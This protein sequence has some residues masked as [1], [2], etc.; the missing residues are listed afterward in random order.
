MSRNAAEVNRVVNEEHHVYKDPNKWHRQ[1]TTWALSFFG[2]AIGAGVLFL[3]INIGQGG[4]LTLLLAL[5]LAY[6]IVYF[7]HRGL[8]KMI[9]GSKSAGDGIT[10]TVHE[11]FGDNGRVIFDIIYFIT[12]YAILIMYA[13]SITN[14]TMS[15]IEN[16]VGVTPPPR[17]LVS[18]VLVLGLIFLVNNGQDTIVRIMEYI[19]YPFIAFLVII[20]FF[21]IPQWDF[22]NI[23]LFGR[24][25]NADG[26]IWIGG[27]LS[28]AWLV[29]P[30]IVFS[31]N[32]FPIISSFVV[33]Q[34]E[35]YGMK[36]IER[37][38]A[39]IQR[40]SYIITVA[41]VMFFGISCV[42]SMSAEDVML[43]QEQNL[44]VLSYLANKFDM[45]FFVWA[46]PIV[47]FIAITKSFLGHYVGAFEGAQ[48]L[49]K[50][51][52]EA[53]DKQFNEKTTK[54]I[55]LGFLI[56]SSWLIAFANPSILDLIDMIN[57]PLIAAIL[58]LLPMYAIYKIPAL[59]KYRK[60]YISNSFVII[61][62]ILVVLSSIRALF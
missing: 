4:V 60:N 2:T 36:H 52:G 22:T 47:S 21:L 55:I 45:P 33:K 23:S 27:I 59:E 62:G 57:A 37:K 5:I 32:H 9:Y 17:I 26:G 11:Y 42:L 54:N 39:Q 34:R 25:T 40:V 7:S 49:I 50:I 31:F 58:C 13:V 15:L 1:D 18:F 61:V 16:Q 6:P 35:T 48:D 46:A 56:I 8:A 20:S 30:I 51:Y 53:M 10:A 44:P 19:V 14:T 24:F 41:V 28:A 12:L 38:T 29:I 43:A 3:P